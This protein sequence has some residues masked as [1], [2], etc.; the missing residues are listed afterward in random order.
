MHVVD[1][2]S[3]AP[4]QRF[5]MSTPHNIHVHVRVHQMNCLSSSVGGVACLECVR[6]G[7][8]SH[9]SAAFSEEKVASGLVLCCVVLCC[10]VFLSKCLSIH[11]HNHYMSECTWFSSGFLIVWEVEPGNEAIY[12]LMMEQQNLRA[13]DN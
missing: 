10:F 7:F 1:W 8:K 3:H 2:Y 4:I 6:R 11:V 9:L 5:V 13:L 12:L